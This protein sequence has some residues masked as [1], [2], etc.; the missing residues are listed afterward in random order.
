MVSNYNQVVAR[1]VAKYFGWDEKSEQVLQ[2]ANILEA[3]EADMIRNFLYAIRTVSP[4][5]TSENYSDSVTELECFQ[6][7]FDDCGLQLRNWAERWIE[8]NNLKT[9]DTPLDKMI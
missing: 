7:G 2:M 1:E 3:K 6:D 9:L 8:V 4:S 5:M